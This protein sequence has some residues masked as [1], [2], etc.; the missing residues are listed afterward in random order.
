MLEIAAHAGLLEIFKTQPKEKMTVIID[1]M[2]DQRV[3]KG[4][5]EVVNGE[6]VEKGT[7]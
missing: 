7:F 4:E 6:E 2:N 3:H 5:K 1:E